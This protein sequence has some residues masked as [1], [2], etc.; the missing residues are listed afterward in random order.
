MPYTDNTFTTAKQDGA[1]EVIFPFLNAPVRDNTCRQ[2][3]QQ[4]AVLPGSFSP[5]AAGSTWP[6]DGVW[7]SNANIYLVRET[8]PRD[9]G[10]F[11]R[12]ERLYSSIPSDQNVYAAA[13]VIRPEMHG[14]TISGLYAA[15]FDGG[16]TSHVWNARVAVTSS[17]I[18]VGAYI[19]QILVTEAGHGRSAGARYALW[20]NNTLMA[21]G[22]I[23]F[24]NN[25]DSYIVQAGDLLAMNENSATHVTH[26][27]S[28][29]ACYV[30]GPITVSTRE[31][32]KF[33]YPGVSGGITTPYD[34]PLVSV[35]TDPLSWL[36]AI[37]GNNTEAVVQGSQLR[38]WEGPIY[39][40]TTVYAQMSDAKETVP[41]GT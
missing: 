16:A 34:I 11:H 22:G 3:R 21:V 29:L 15:T 38:Q 7:A 18:G 39:V 1:T 6:G 26:A 9:A 32:S 41:V 30:N 5:L 19:G 13:T 36:R 4:M 2:Y 17:R 14:V 35:E 23:A 24:I 40:Q 28:A 27:A 25:T 33:Y 31:L 10:G 20:A 8:D 37:A 12:F